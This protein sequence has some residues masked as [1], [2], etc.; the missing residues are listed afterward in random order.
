MRSQDRDTATQ[1]GQ[2]VEAFD[3]LAHNTEDAPRIGVRK[4]AWT[5]ALEQLLVR[6]CPRR[7][8]AACLFVSF[9]SPDAHDV[10]AGIDVDDLAV[11]PE[12]IELQRNTAVVP[13]SRASTLRPSGARSA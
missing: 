7:F 12:D 11:I 5:R 9:P 4:L 2:F 13:T 6:C 3:K 8:S 1:G 10:V